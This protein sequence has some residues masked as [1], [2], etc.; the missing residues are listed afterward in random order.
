MTGKGWELCPG[1]EA[2]LYGSRLARDL[3]VCSLCGHHLRMT[4][5]QRL[6]S[7]LDDGSLEVVGI[8]VID[9]DPLLFTDTASYVSRREAARDRTGLSEAAVCATGT[10]GGW[11]LVVVAM[12]FRFMGG[13][14]GSAVGE[15]ITQAGELALSRHI[16][17]LVVCASGGARMQEGALSLMQMAKTSQLFGQL[18]AAGILTI[19]LVTD[20]TFGGVAASYATLAD[21]IIVEPGARLGF[22]GPRVIAQTIGRPL[23]A[24]FQTA[25]FLIEHGL[26]DMR[27][28]RS[29]LRS[30][31]TRLLATAPPSSLSTVESNMVTEPDLVE[32]RD[33]W[34]AVRAA[35]DINRPTAVDYIRLVFADFV[36]LRGDRLAKDCPAVVGGV[37]RLGSTPVMI[38]GTQKGH[39]AEELATHNFGMASPAGYRKAARLMRLAAKLSL[40]VITLI[41]TPGAHP[42]IEAEENGQALAIAENL[43]LMAGLDVPT[44]AVVIG[45]GGSGGALALAVADQVLMFANAVYSVISP[46]GCAA[47][48]WN[49]R[50]A[51]PTAA[52][53]LRMDARSLLRLGVVDGVIPE[54]P[55]GTQ[56]DHLAAAELLCLALTHTLAQLT[57]VPPGERAARRYS[58]FRRFGAPLA[59]A[60]WEGA[61]SGR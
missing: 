1:C 24:G 48:L 61:A 38:I 6:A 13:S 18:D 31:L 22:A 55:D 12:D 42:G 57:N 46:E 19:S 35:R 2:V 16:P 3:R 21:V 44:I 43:R 52:A 39:T 27:C 29:E 23:P 33:P 10:I 45:E 15:V 9:G 51:A 36:G 54:P 17:L 20:P 60:A 4:A 7:L 26:V 14:L 53:A 56:G 32:Q 11:P 37:G 28:P 50:A 49:D 47:I 59:E 25:E 34:E 58:R 41:D 5:T 8:P 40:P 30:R